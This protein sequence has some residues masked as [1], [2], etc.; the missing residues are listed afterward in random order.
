[1]P[2]EIISQT[3]ALINEIRGKSKE[4]LPTQFTINGVASEDKKT[5]ANKFNNYFGSLAENLNKSQSSNKK[6]SPCFSKYLPNPNLSQNPHQYFLK[7][8]PLTR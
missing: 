6:L 7:I 2:Q 8:L 1:M 5:I 4:S 3:W